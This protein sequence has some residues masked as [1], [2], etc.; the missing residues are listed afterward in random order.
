MNPRPSLALIEPSAETSAAPVKPPAPGYGLVCPYCG[1]RETKPT[2]GGGY[3]CTN[4]PCKGAPR[5]RGE[6]GRFA[7][8]L[9][10][11]S[12]GGARLRPWYEALEIRR[13]RRANPKALLPVAR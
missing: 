12:L 3:L 9:V 1:A 13:R 4:R 7:S 5:S 8:I 10:V 2:G 6:L 11:D